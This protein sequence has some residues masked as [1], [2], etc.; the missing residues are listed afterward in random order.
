MKLYYEIQ[1]TVYILSYDEIDEYVENY[2]KGIKGKDV[3]PVLLIPFKDVC[4]YL[5]DNNARCDVICYNLD[6]EDKIYS[7]GERI[8]SI[9]D[10][11]GT[12]LLMKNQSLIITHAGTIY[13]IEDNEI[14]GNYVEAK[15]GEK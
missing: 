10:D 7:K 4:P 9:L 13:T 2:L 1:D 15:K 6:K 8:Y 14:L 12:N 3:S 5:K 11:F